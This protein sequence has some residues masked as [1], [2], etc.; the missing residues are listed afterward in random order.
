MMEIFAD[1]LSYLTL[2]KKEES[3]FLYLYYFQPFII[4]TR[5]ACT[6]SFQYTFV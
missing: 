4:Q 2:E 5:I 1:L 3:G 6:T